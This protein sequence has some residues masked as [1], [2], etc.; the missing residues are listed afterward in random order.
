LSL[1]IENKAKSEE[2]PKSRHFSLIHSN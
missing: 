2:W 1:V